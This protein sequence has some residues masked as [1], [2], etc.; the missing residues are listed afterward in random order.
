[1]LDSLR[2]GVIALG[3]D[4]TLTAA[5]PAAERLLGFSIGDVRFTPWHLLPWASLCGEDGEALSPADHPVVATLGD[6]RPRGPQV[7]GVRGDDD[8]RWLELTTHVF[9]TVGE[10]STGGVV[11]SFQDVTERVSAEAERN[12][13]IELLRDVMSGA[14]HDVRNPLAIIQGNADMLHADWQVMSDEERDRSLEMIARRS[15]NIA[16]VIDDLAVMSQ[17]EGGVLAVDRRPVSA[18]SIVDDALDG[19]PADGRDEVE[20]V[21]PVDVNVLVDPDHARR[22][23]LNLLENAFKYGAPPVRISVRQ[24]DDRVVFRVT[25]EGDG[26]APDVADRLFDRFSRGSTTDGLAGM[27]LGL[28][29]VNRLARLNGGQVTYEPRGSVGAGFELSLPA[30]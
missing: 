5:N 17:L 29:I 19:V 28:A 6:G 24:Q 11:V 25:D 27:G 3:V 20:V 9:D 2:E 16:R 1:M 18:A 30:P 15:K 7:V 23:L 21:P 26:V 12:R 22:M 8:V 4:G 14:T 10:Q 13:L